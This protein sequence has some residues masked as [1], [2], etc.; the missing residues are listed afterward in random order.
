M[1]DQQLSGGHP[2]GQGTAHRAARR[3]SGDVKDS[4]PTVTLLDL[5][6]CSHGFERAVEDGR[7]RRGYF[8]LANRVVCSSLQ[9]TGFTQA[10]SIQSI[11][12]QVPHD[13]FIKKDR[14]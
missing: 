8:L 7:W 12:Q 14:L 9:T 5:W 10:S 13:R 4:A 3:M 2:R 1:G 6:Y 11:A